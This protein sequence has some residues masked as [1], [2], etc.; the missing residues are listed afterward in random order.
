MDA[1]EAAARFQETLS[2]LYEYGYT[3]GPGSL[4]LT[5]WVEEH[6]TV[7]HNLVDTGTDWRIDPPTRAQGRR[8]S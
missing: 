4:S 3:V 2:E 6:G 8:L 1:R 5:Q 7:V